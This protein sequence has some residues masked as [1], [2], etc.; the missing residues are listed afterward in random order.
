MAYSVDP[1]QEL[2]RVFSARLTNTVLGLITGKQ[3]LS[4]GA[5][6]RVASAL[7]KIA[8][9]LEKQARIEADCTGRRRS[10]VDAG[11]H[12]YL[13]PPSE[14]W[15]IRP[16]VAAQLIS[17]EDHPEAYR[18]SRTGGNVKTEIGPFPEM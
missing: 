17:R 7:K 18:L 5:K 4:C 16:D 6:V 11:V 1:G 10:H 13:V 9:A 15:V 8:A 2:R 3:P 12:F 14:D